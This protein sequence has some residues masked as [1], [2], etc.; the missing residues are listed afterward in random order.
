MMRTFLPYLLVGFGGFLGA[1]ARFLVG[2][3]VGSAVGMRFP[4]GTL[5]INVSGSFLLGI[6]GTLIAE[7]VVSHPEY[8]QFGLAVGFLG[9]YTTFSTFSYENHAILLDGEWWTAA[10]NIVL[11]VALGLVAVRLGVIVTKAWL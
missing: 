9:A 3:W 7:R 10:M 11:S 4:L 2:S 6:I 1:N 8:V 5:I